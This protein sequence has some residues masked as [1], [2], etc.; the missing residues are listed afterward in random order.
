M[1]Y[2]RTQC[3]CHGCDALLDV[4]EA[5]RMLAVE[6]K[7]LMNQKMG[8]YFNKDDRVLLDKISNLCEVISGR[9]KQHHSGLTWYG[10][11][12]H[13]E[14]S[15]YQLATQFAHRCIKLHLNLQTTL[16]T[17][18]PEILVAVMR[19]TDRTTL[20]RNLQSW[21]QDHENIFHLYRQWMVYQPKAAWEHIEPRSH[22]KSSIYRI[23]ESRSALHDDFELLHK[24]YLNPQIGIQFKPRICHCFSMCWV[25]GETVSCHMVTIP[26]FDDNIEEHLESLSNINMNAC[27][28]L[29]SL[30]LIVGCSSSPNHHFSVPFSKPKFLSI[31]RFFEIPS[32]YLQMIFTETSQTLSYKHEGSLE[33]HSFIFRSPKTILPRNDWGLCL[34]HD[35]KRN[36]TTGVLLGMRPRERDHFLA[37]LESMKMENF[38]PMHIPVWLCEAQTDRDSAEV[39]RHAAGLHDLTVMSIMKDSSPRM[40]IPGEE[41]DYALMTSKLNAATS[42]LSHLQL[43]FE[44]TID[45]LKYIAT[46]EGDFGENEKIREALQEKLHQLEAENRALLAEVLCN[47]RISQ[48]L[49]Q[50]VFNMITERDSGA[51]LSMAKASRD[52]AEATKADSSAMRTLAFMSIVFLPATFVSSFFSMSMFDWRAPQLTSIVSKRM[53]IYWVVSIP[54]TL[55]IIVI[56][57]LWL[58]IDID[59]YQ[60][61]TQSNNVLAKPKSQDLSTKLSPKKVAEKVQEWSRL[62][63]RRRKPSQDEEAGTTKPAT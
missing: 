62:R 7:K 59:Q 13:L 29:P 14:D 9:T 55:I 26:V 58:R 42:R 11:P 4:S 30:D 8:T 39:K 37:S 32:A 16:I 25:P 40:V 35:E 24:V 51:N 23:K 38:H 10:T 31:L 5:A 47:Q 49:M 22:A 36:H 54:L 34:T 17:L 6:S 50:F 45:S 20:F 63:M 2:F 56:W 1:D 21:H 28:K 48:S 19:E 46:C 57:Q 60:K 53:W 61:S 12:P 18:I 15:I 43:R 3:R 41:L 52:L 44:S 27:G 33:K